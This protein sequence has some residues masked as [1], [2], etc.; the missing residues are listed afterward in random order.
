MKYQ[1]IYFSLITLIFISMNA[2][3]Q[4]RINHVAVYVKDLK[5]S[6][7]FYEKVVGLKEIEE[8][9]KDG[10]HAWYEMGDGISLHL[11]EREE[12][13]TN[14]TI[15]KTNHL[16]FSVADLDAFIA[17]LDQNNIPFEDWPGKKG[18]INIR[19]DGIKQIYI[20]DPS[21]YWLEINDEY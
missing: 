9:F 16:C 15:D 4:T 18:E 21:G 1:K 3:T 11:I 2:Y 6:S 17:R 10:L 8:P 14:P 20:R 7:H 19:P 5:E 13:W 12:R